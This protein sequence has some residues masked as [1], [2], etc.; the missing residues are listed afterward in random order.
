[1]FHTFQTHHKPDLS[2]H[3]CNEPKFYF[4]PN[5]CLNRESINFYTMLQNPFIPL[6]NRILEF[7]VFLIIKLKLTIFLKE[8]RKKNVEAHNEYAVLISIN[9]IF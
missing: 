7:N 3:L 6:N 5:T 2:L 9:R 8:R 1:M 4:S